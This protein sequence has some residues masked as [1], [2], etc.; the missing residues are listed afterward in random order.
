MRLTLMHNPE[1]GDDQPSEDELVALLRDAGHEVRYQ[2]T[3]DPAFARAFEDPVD[4]VFV[5]G[6]DGTVAKVAKQLVGRAVPLAIAPT[7]TSNN[8]ARSLGIHGSPRE[9]IDGIPTAAVTMLDV[10]R[11]RAPWGSSRFIE[12]V[13]VGFF[14]SVLRRVEERREAGTASSST[15]PVTTALRGICRALHF[16]RP[17]HRRV[18]ADG[19]DLSGEYLMA[20]V[21]NVR[22][23]GP[24]MTLAP[25]AD[26]GDGALDLVLVGESDRAALI[27]YLTALGDDRDA[28]CPIPARRARRVRVEWSAGQGH[29]DD[30]VWPSRELP[31]RELV[32]DGVTMVEA[33]IVDPPITVLVPRTAGRS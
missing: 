23:I 28:P 31:D 32:A 17:C 20:A 13:G 14:G 10:G 8:I 19:E 11:A 6:G 29:L 27:D 25:V 9:I 2:S 12:A 7:G 16:H 4:L 1:A 18:M 33:E 26:L 30:E 22:S 24:R 5:A 3:K 21:L 15:T